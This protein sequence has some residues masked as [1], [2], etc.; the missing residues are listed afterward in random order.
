[1]A[2]RPG[3]AG[4]DAVTLVN[5]ANIRIQEAAH[6][7]AKLASEIRANVAAVQRGEG[8]FGDI[9]AAAQLIRRNAATIIGELILNGIS[10]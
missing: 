6:D 10:K 1:M 7:I 3:R 5:D 9:D 2:P 8:K 4:G